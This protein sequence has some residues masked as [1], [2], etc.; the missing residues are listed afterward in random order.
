MNKQTKDLKNL[1]FTSLNVIEKSCKTMAKSFGTD[2]IPMNMYLTVLVKAQWK[3]EGN[4]TA[5]T[6]AESY[7]A[8][9]DELGKEASKELHTSISLVAISLMNRKVKESFTKGLKEVG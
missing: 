5:K 3:V 6:Y 1:V 9:L 8:M 2:Y 4:K 7:N